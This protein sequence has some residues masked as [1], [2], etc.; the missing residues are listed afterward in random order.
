MGVR[1]GHKVTLTV[2]CAM[3]GKYRAHMDDYFIQVE[4]IERLVRNLATRHG[5]PNCEVHVNAADNSE[6]K[7]IYLTVT[8]TSAES[9]DDGQVGRGNRV[10]SLI[11]PGR[12]MSLEAATGKNPV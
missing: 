3:K 6:E 8:G 11:T 4:A 9:G 1:Y 10:N 5:F 12:P 2:A 7:A